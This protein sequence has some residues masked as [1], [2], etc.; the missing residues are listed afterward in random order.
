MIAAGRK[1]IYGSP[2]LE[3]KG[4]VIRDALDAFLAGY[5]RIFGSARAN[6]PTS[7]EALVARVG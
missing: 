4:M 1:Y 2:G 6:L 3:D 5:E 7:I